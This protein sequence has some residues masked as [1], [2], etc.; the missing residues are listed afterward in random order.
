MDILAAVLLLGIRQWFGY[1]AAVVHGIS[2]L[3][4]SIMTP[5]VLNES[6]ENKQLINSTYAV[7]PLNFI[8]STWQVNAWNASPQNT[9][10]DVFVICTTSNDGL[11]PPLSSYN[12][13]GMSVV[14]K[15]TQKFWIG[16]ASQFDGVCVQRGVVTMYS[17]H[18]A[19]SPYY[20]PIT[21]KADCNQGNVLN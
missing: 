14:Y 4:G 12:P 2:D 19:I 20:T 11:N 18:G 5:I 17:D 13:N 10:T 6:L 3:N 1:A 16:S 9:F 21:N 15:M 7:L 8:P